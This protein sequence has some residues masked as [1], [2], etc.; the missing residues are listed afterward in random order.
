MNIS[1]L[2]FLCIFLFCA[3]CVSAQERQIVDEMKISSL[4]AKQNF[5]GLKFLSSTREDVIAAYGEKCS[6]QCVI[7]DDWFIR[8][9]YV[10]EVL[11][12][13]RDS[14]KITTTR[15]KL[16]YVGKLIGVEFTPRKQLFLADD[17]VLPGNFQCTP[18][19]LGNCWGHENVTL[20]FS[21]QTREDGSL[22]ARKINYIFH[23]VPKAD[24]DKITG[25][26]EERS[27]T[28]E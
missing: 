5:L 21:Y 12:V 2:L 1:K 6:N 25:E 4:M 9:V 28:N 20:H 24:R 22:F 8:F 26:V 10:G 7:D 16:A 15:S 3:I 27:A 19:Y 17:F 11:K 14:D 23:G 13:R 18:R